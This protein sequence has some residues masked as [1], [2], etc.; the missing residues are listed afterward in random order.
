MK[1]LNNILIA[2]LMVMSLTACDK[3]PV[4]NVGVKVYLLGGSKGVDVEELS[5]GRY[6]IGIN[7]ELF[8]FPTYT[9]NYTWTVEPDETGNEDES[10]SFQTVEGLTVNADVGISYSITPDKVATIFQKYRK[11]INEITDIYL[12]NMVRDA[13]VTAASTKPIAS[14]YGAG[15]AELIQ[16]TEKHVRDQVQPLGI[17]IERIYWTGNLR[18][19]NSVTTAINEKISATQKAAQRENE[20]AQAKA[21]AEKVRVSA[22]GDADAKLLMAEAEAKAIR[23]KGEALA[24]N[25]KLIEWSAIEKWNGTLPQFTGGG[26]IPFINVPTANN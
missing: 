23:V 17:N 6:W 22:Q 3:V 15:K 4:G 16:A 18:L 7:E 25:P 20:V 21:E 5:P 1:M 19:P 24:N 14:V 2:A 8:L 12:R 13:L 11:G 9:Q 26:A 10:I